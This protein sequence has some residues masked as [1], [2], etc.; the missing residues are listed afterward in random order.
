M[1]DLQDKRQRATKE[2]LEK[3]APYLDANGI[4]ANQFV[5]KPE[6]PS[7]AL[8]GTRCVSMFASELNKKTD[9]YICLTNFDF[10]ALDDGLY[11]YKHN[12]HWKEEYTTNQFIE[13]IQDYTYN[14]PTELMQRV[15][16]T[17]KASTQQ[18]LELDVQFI[19]TDQDAMMESLTIRDLAAIMMKAPLSKKTWLNTMI[20]QA[21]TNYK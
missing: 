6:Y 7:K 14:V 17:V 21:R 16:T 15:E 10:E 12:L 3:H 9:L 19:D 18:K 8:G 4:K 13:K 11:L 20:D 5:L 1:S 2:L